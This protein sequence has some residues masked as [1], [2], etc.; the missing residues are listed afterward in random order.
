MSCHFLFQGILPNQGLNLSL[1][2][3]QV[4]SLPLCKCSKSHWCWWL[5]YCIHLWKV[6]TKKPSLLLGEKYILIELIFENWKKINITWGKGCIFVLVLF[7]VGETGW[8]WVSWNCTRSHSLWTGPTHVQPWDE[9]LHGGRCDI[10]NFCQWVLSGVGTQHTHAAHTWM[11]TW[12]PQCGPLY[13]TTL[14]HNTF[15]SS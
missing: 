11:S 8:S 5:W 15:S 9:E 10:T 2:H 4:D 14:P 1:L 13:C 6:L 7:L 3:W 12:K